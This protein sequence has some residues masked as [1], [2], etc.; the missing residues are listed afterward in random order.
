M[1]LSVCVCLCICV[2]V[3]VSLSL[4]LCVSVSL[5]VFMCLCVSGSLCVSVCLSVCVSVCVSV[6]LCLCV[7]VSVCLS[8]CVLHVQ[9]WVWRSPPADSLA[10]S[11]RRSTAYLWLMADITSRVS[12]VKRGQGSFPRVM[13]ASPPLLLHKTQA[14]TARRTALAAAATGSCLAWVLTCRGARGWRLPAAEN[15]CPP[16]SSPA[17]AGSSYR[18]RLGPFSAELQPLP[19]IASKRTVLS[20]RTLQN[21]PAE[22]GV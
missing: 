5:C 22:S 6:C 17:L 13:C 12:E 9:P 3:C 1:C 21:R 19:R 11:P 18:L 20:S 7:C 15:S 10:P 16:D 14:P 4:C 2:C 8:V